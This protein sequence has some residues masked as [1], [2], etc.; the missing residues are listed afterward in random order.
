MKNIRLI[1]LLLILIVI[2]SVQTSIAQNT[3]FKLSDYKNPD[4]LYQTLDLNFGLNSSLNYTK[5]S[6]AFDFSRNI[7]SF[8]SAASATYS[9]YSNSSKF[10]AEKHITLGGGIGSGGYENSTDYNNHESKNNT[11]THNENLDITFLKRFYNEKQ[12]YFELNTSLNSSGYGTSQKFK[13]YNSDS[14][15]SSQESGDTRFLNTVSGSFLIGKGRIEQVQD[16]RL[17]LYLLDDLHRLNRDKRSVSDADIL[18][19]ARLITS[20]KYKRFFDSRLRQIAEITAID[21]FMQSN[22]IAGSRDASYFTSINDNWDFANNPSRFSG[23]RIFTGIEA[24]FTYNYTRT[25][26]ENTL[27]TESKNETTNNLHGGNI[28]AVA[29]INYE[30]PIS[31]KWQQSANLK[32]GVGSH[33]E[34][35]SI[36]EADTSNTT[37]IDS[38]T[39]RFPSIMLAAD[40]GYGY[41]PNSRTWLTANWQFTSGYDKQMT[42]TSRKDKKDYQNNFY[43]NTGP[44]I[45]AYYYISEK[46]RL[47]FTFIGQLSITKDKST[48]SGAPQAPDNKSTSTGWNQSLIAALTYSL[49]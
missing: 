8:N 49:F 38:F 14:L 31:I 6:S 18:A 37:N 45:Q 10:Q 36:S 33:Y 46:L 5:N 11:F 39:G 13:T 16:A 2:L 12:N 4:Y 15:T 40:Y 24:G 21:S 19:L 9:S 32:A 47:S 35:Q 23:R 1:Q 43:A 30:K 3:P 29:G 20:L 34:I 44:R 22:R 17:A 28:F 7:Y 27:P 25:N 48:Y 42:G 41:Y 26:L